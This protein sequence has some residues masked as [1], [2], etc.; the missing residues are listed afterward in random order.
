MIGGSLAL[1][2]LAVLL[3][4]S[5]PSGTRMAERLAADVSTSA[6]LRTERRRLWWVWSVLALLALAAAYA[7]GD[8]RAVAVVTALLIIVA[9]VARLSVQDFRGRRVARARTE[10]AHAC[11]VLASQIRVG[12]VPAEALHSAAVDCPVLAD[13]SRVQDLGGDVSTAWRVTS[14]RPG[15]AGLGDLARAWQ[16]S[17][18]TGA[19]LARSLEQV[20][21]ALTA[22]VALRTVVAGELAASRATG[23]IMAALPFLGLGMGYLLGGD[24]LHFL[25]SNPYGWTCL[26]V[27]VAL[28]AAGVLWIDWLSRLAAEQ[29]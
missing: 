22:E 25:L 29:G 24:P 11:S 18:Q 7:L 21:E 10:V 1:V 2:F 26:V 5:P 23:K 20:S 17:S 6:P 9:T 16:M 8:L 12:R 14:T 4:I 13:A 27:G 15:H 28:A 19:P 3:F